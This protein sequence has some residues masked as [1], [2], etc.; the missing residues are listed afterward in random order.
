MA[1]IFK[2]KLFIDPI[3]RL[4]ES[5]QE[6][7]PEGAAGAYNNWLTSNHRGLARGPVDGGDV[8]SLLANILNKASGAHSPSS[9]AVASS[10]CILIDTH[11]DEAAADKSD[12]GAWQPVSRPTHS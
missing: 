12:W 10:V 8:G 5:A 1:H 6:E 3:H 11:G 7:S 4:E 2:F 9:H